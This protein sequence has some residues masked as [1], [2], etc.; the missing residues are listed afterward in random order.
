VTVSGEQRGTGAA[1]GDSHTGDTDLAVQLEVP[2][3][4]LLPVGRGT[5]IFCF[6]TCFHRRGQVE[7]LDIVVDGRRHGV[8]ASGMP[9]PDLFRALHPSLSSDEE[10]SLERDPHSSE[11]PELRSYR[12]GFWATVPIE[13]R[14]RPGA[15]ELTVDV[16]L[17]DGGG[18]SAAL[19]RIEVIEPGEPPSY[20]DLPDRGGGLIAVCMATFDPDIELFRVQIDSLR[21]QTDTNWICLISDDCSQPD[22]FEAIERTIGGDPRFVVSRSQKHLSFYRNFERALGMVPAEAELVALCDHDDR[23][24]PE[25]LETLRGALGGAQLVYS[26]QRLV[27]ADGRVLADTFWKGRR[28]NY[29]N[30][31]SLL[32][33]NTI[34]GAAT[35]FR[36]EMLEFA[37]P[38]PDM[39][40]LEFHDHWLSLVAM[41]TGDIRYVDRPLYDYVQHAEAVLGKVAVGSEGPPDSDGTTRRSLRERLRFFTGGRAAY[42]CAYLHL[43]VQA[44]VLHERCSARLTPRK[45]RALRRFLASAHSPLSLLWLA[46]RPLRALV[47]RN[48]T[49]VGEIQHVKG[50]LW[51]YIVALRTRR[52]ERPDGSRYDASLPLCWQVS[53]GQLRLRRWR[54]RR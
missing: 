26:D 47:G 13:P 41:A 24:Y 42:F 18:A 11:D 6:G 35:L 28:N 27:D 34:T 44:H 7:D 49:F 32:I 17:A 43:Q 46:G 52:L 50:I 37:L 31:P 40:G 25:K 45:R 1:V 36:R 48:E 20:P 21:A 16:R 12:S 33:A 51:R 53:F 29:T 14:D 54:A 19:G 39:P 38:F 5:A 8:T 15:I 3:P 22:R 2:V 4:R 23:W 30:F 9:R 10:A